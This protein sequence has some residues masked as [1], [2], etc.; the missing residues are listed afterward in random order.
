MAGFDSRSPSQRPGL[1]DWLGRVLEE[2]FEIQRLL[3]TGGMGA[4]FVAFDRRLEQ[5]VAVKVL[6]SWELDEGADA[7]QRR[8]ESEARVLA[9]LRDPRI[10][11]PITWGRTSDGGLYF[12]TE[13]LEGTPLDLEIIERGPLEPVRAVRLLLDVCSALGE[14]HAAGVVHRDVKP[15]NIFIQRS[16][17]GEEVARLLDFGVAKQVT[18]GTKLGG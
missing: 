15:G 3:A 4:V 16:R 11:R 13:L 5:K 14:A 6:P 17:S 12:V 7:V 9:R 8:F 1:R 18:G 2:R 10:L